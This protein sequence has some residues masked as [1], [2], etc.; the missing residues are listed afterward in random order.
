MLRCCFRPA[1]TLAEVLITLGILGVVSA[2]T[3][4]VLI[5]KHNR[6]VVETRLKKFYSSI[7]QAILMAE[8]DFGDKRDWYQ[9]LKNSEIDGE[10]NPIEGTNE[11]EKWF[12]KYIAPYMVIIKKETLSD[13]AFLVYFPDG[14]ALRPATDFTRDWYFYPS[15][16]KK[17]MDMYGVG[18]SPEGLGVC[19]FAFNFYPISDSHTWKYHY[20]K[21]MEP[22]KCSWTGDKNQL[23]KGSSYSCDTGSGLY[24]TAIIQL[25]NWTIPDDYPR[26]IRN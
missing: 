12:N 16:P 5:Q 24:C 15:N 2:M 18:Y 1:F 20:N 7:N 8:N 9:D 21:G 26:R 4:P 6:R 17:C 10:G 14:S 25:N 19:L 22:Y 3:M 13:G 23:Y 11:A